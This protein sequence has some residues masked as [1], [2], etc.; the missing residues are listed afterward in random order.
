MKVVSAREVLL[1]VTLLTAGNGCGGG[2]NRKIKGKIIQNGQPI[3]QANIAFH[4]TDDPKAPAMFGCR[5]DA[6]GEFEVTMPPSVK[7]G[8]FKVTVI[9]F[10]PKEGVTETP[11]MDIEQLR[12]SGK[13]KNS[14]PESYE[15]AKTTP[16]TASVKAGQKDLS[17]EVK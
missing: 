9:K 7:D 5:S 11:E 16:L 2:E 3:A 14:L 6:K 15:S 17:L 8:S 4:A 1:V 12:R 13:A 10:V